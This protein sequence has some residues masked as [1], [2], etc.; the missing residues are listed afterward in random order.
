MI[1]SPKPRLKELQRRILA[2]ILDKIPP[3]PA[4]HGFVKGRS[5]RTFVAPHV[6]QCVVLRMDLR[7]FFP[8]VSGS[9][10]SGSVSHHRLSGRRRVAVCRNLHQ[11]SAARRLEGIRRRNGALRAAASSARRAGV[12]IARQSL[13]A[14]CGLPA[15][16]PCGIGRRRLHAICRRPGVLRRRGVRTTRGPLLDSRGGDAAGRG[17]RSAAPQDTH[18]AAERAATSGGVGDES[19]R[20]RAPP[21]F[22]PAQSGAHQL[23]AAGSGE[24]EPRVRMPISARIW[25]GA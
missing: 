20:Q 17:F 9:A 19:A 7:D 15:H 13:R 25:R 10:C 24:S 16:R 22:R 6:G 21:R 14:A 5:I 18:H 4:A 23:R 12:A 8:D 2:D 3:H 1:E 11:R